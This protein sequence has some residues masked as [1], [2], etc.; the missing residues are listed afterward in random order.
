MKWLKW[1]TL[2]L[3]LLPA[4]PVFAAIAFDQVS[5]CSTASTCSVTVSATANSFLLV[6]VDGDVGGAANAVSCTYNSVAM[7]KLNSQTTP[8]DR[9][10]YDLYTFGVSGTHTL[11]CSGPTFIRII[12][13]S[14]T[15]VNQA[16]PN[17]NGSNSSA[18][19]VVSTALTA[20]TASDW[21]VAV[22]YGHGTQTG[23]GVLPSAFRGQGPDT[24]TVFDSGG[25]VPSGSNTGTITMNAGDISMVAVDLTPAAGAAVVPVK[26]PNIIK[27]LG[28]W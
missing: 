22:G 7:T 19:T 28:F 1:I 8:S 26:V 10:I 13:A 23:S 21:F 9:T 5:N 15:G 16:A 11:T 20:A 27:W 3:L 12:D 24:N 14:W 18:T 2:L 17:T 4:S 25:A 6:E